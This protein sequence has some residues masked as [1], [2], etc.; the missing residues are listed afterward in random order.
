MSEKKEEVPSGCATKYAE[1]IKMGKDALDAV[2]APFEVRRASKDLEK[3]II[4]LE[5]EIAE[6]ELDIVKAKSGKPFKLDVILIAIDAK[7]L[8]ERELRLANELQK[9]LF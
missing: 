3:A 6:L 2:K 1:L 9:E 7:D 8:K 4:D 5:Q